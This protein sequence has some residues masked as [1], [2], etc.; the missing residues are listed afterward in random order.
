MLMC[1]GGIALWMRRW[2]ARRA[3]ASTSTPNKSHPSLKS[4]PDSNI[5]PRPIRA[6]TVH[7]HRFDARIDGIRARQHL[8]R[9]GFC[10]FK[11][12]AGQQALDNTKALFWKWLESHADLG[13]RWGDVDSLMHCRW[14]PLSS[15]DTMFRAGLIS[16]RG[17]GQSEMMW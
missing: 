4:S 2:S 11:D 3:R 8:R 12:V 9:H 7:A 10:V 5:S 14:R 16:Q 13:L 6:P 1:V 17:I 15:Q